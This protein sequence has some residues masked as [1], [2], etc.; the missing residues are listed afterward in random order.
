[1]KK[2]FLIALCAIFAVATVASAADVH[3]II[4]QKPLYLVDGSTGASY[5]VLKG[6][7][8]IAWKDGTRDGFF[9]VK[10]QVANVFIPLEYEF[11]LVAIGNCS[12]TMIEGIFDVKRNGVL[13][14]SGIVGRVYGLDQPVGSYFKFYGGDSSCFDTKWHVSAYITAR[15]DY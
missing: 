1:M 4:A 3:S 10:V 9:N 2:A 15:V 11:Q 6:C 5:N 7:A 12:A 14:A 13:V 8:T